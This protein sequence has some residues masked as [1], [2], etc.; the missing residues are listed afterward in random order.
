LPKFT[1]L[2]GFN[3]RLQ[4]GSG[5]DNSTQ[6]IRR[7]FKN[8]DVALTEVLLITDILIGGD[9]KV[10]MS[11]CKTQQFTVFDA[12]PTTIACR[13]ALM[14]SKD[15]AHWYWKAFVQQDP[16]PFYVDN[17]AVSERSNIRQAM[18]RLTDGKQARNSSSV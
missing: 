7:E 9:K 11:F 14:F 17:N 2:Y 16:H 6:I 5:S 4:Q 18:S 15:I 3:G 12:F 10:E 1:R 8:G 13:Y